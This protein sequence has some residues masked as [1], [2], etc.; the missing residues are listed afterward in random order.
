M[1]RRPPSSTRTDTLFPYTTLF[2]SR[3]AQPGDH[4]LLHRRPAGAAEL[5]H[6][7]G[8]EAH[9]RQRADHRPDCGAAAVVPGER[10]GLVRRSRPLA[11]LF[12][13]HRRP[14]A[15]SAPETLAPY[16]STGEAVS[17]VR[18]SEERRVGKACVSTCSSRWSTS[19]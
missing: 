17:D 14:H 4:L 11:A 7:T 15:P 1:F 5:P 19:H 6:G 3:W 12:R 10:T 16:L 8:P 2:L 13:Q 9:L 18:S